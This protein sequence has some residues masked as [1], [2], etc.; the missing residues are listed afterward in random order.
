MVKQ[1]FG[2]LFLGAMLLTAC[3]PGS[4][5]Q[6][7]PK[8]GKPL[9]L[10]PVA[11]PRE[12][13]IEIWGGIA[14]PLTHASFKRYWMRGPAAGFAMYFRASEHVKIG[15]GAEAT[16]F[17]F[18]A[19]NFVK[20]NPTV[21]AQVKDIVAVNVFLSMRRYFQPTLRTSPFIGAEVGFTR[22]TGAEYKDF[23]NNVRIT[24]YD[25]PGS[26]RLTASA[27]FGIDHYLSRKIALQGEARLTY[28]HND[29][30]VGLFLGARAGLKFTL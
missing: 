15:F 8:A 17:S 21:P 19:G 20:W 7:K 26:F 5:A 3:S 28:L 11:L 14:H 10:T 12:R 30:N 1:F 22:I 29:P 24:Y 23:I 13:T 16:L 9:P 2:V 27:T 4:N 6:T 18:R 25:V